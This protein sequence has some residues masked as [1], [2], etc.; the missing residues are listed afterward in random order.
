MK[1]MALVTLLT[2]SM[3]MGGLLMPCRIGYRCPPRCFRDHHMIR[4]MR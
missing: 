4:C 3:V 1:R 2:L